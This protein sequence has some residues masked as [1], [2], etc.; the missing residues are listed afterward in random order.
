MESVVV[1]D[2]NGTLLDFAALDSFFQ[3]SFGDV[4][5]RREWFSEVMKM[6]LVSSVIS[7]YVDFGRITQA[8]LKVLEERYR[9]TLTAKQR[10]ELSE[11]LHCL[12]PFPDVKE[13]LETLS[14]T[15]IRLVALT[16]SGLE[17]AERLLQAAGLKHHF[18]RVLSADSVRRLKPSPEP[19][20]M[21]ARECSVEIK[22][23][24][25]V[26]AHSWDIAG[27]SRAG[28]RTCFIYRP[29]EVLDEIFP[30]PDF[31]ATSIVELSKQLR[32]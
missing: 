6:M 17:T 30:Q 13:K 4:R 1:F 24:L 31:T 3:Q 29:G 32:R 19:Y 23:L 27:A 15:G 12:P 5:I 18:H 9:Q 11:V 7:R 20:E 26:A 14:K 8:A 2:V 25:M 28:C 21:A 10:G 22:S 16:N